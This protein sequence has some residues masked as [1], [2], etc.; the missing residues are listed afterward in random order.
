MRLIDADKLLEDRY[1]VIDDIPLLQELPNK[2]VE[3]IRSQPTVEA[4]S[5]EWVENHIKQL[6]DDIVNGFDNA[7]VSYFLSMVQVNALKDMLEDWEKENGR[8]T[9]DS[10]N[11]NSI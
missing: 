1:E 9:N 2:F 8:K 10:K 7:G 6:S 5:I 3:I 11:D 4:I